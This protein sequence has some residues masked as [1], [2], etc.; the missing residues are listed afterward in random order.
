MSEVSDR[1]LDGILIRIGVL[2]EGNALRLF[3]LN[4]I[5]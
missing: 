1:T 3:N 4:N 5:I 2:N